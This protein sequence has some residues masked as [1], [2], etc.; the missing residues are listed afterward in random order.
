LLKYFKTFGRV[1]LK[2]EHENH[3]FTI[4]NLREIT[5]ES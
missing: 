4:F 2:L 1:K 3:K 5:M